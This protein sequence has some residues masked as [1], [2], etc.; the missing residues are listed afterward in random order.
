MSLIISLFGILLTIFLVVGVHEFG[1]F[2]VA[3]LSGIKVLRFS[4]GFG[5]P[6]YRWYD[7]KGTE[8]VLAAIP[9]GGYVKMV[10]EREENVLASD[11][12][13]SFNRQPLYKRIAVICAGPFSNLIFAALLYWLLFVIGFTTIKPIIGEV[14][15]NSIAAMAGLKPQQEILQIDHE[16][17]SGW[18]AVIIRLFEHAGDQGTLQIQATSPNA[19]QSTNYQLN[20][21]SWKMDELK[22]DPLKS[23][24][25][26]PYAP[27]IPAV[28]DVIQPN[29]PAE[30]AGLKPKDQIIAIGNQSIKDWMEIVNIIA[31]APEQ[32]LEFHIIRDKKEMTLPV[33][34]GVK[35]AFFVKKYGYLGMMPHY[36]L[37]P[38]L[39]RH[40]QYGPIAAIPK[41]YSQVKL[42]THM[43]FI[44]LEKL[45]EG[46][47]SLKSLGGPLTIFESAGTAL[48]NGIIPFM[49]FLAFL[50]ISIGIINIFPIPGLDGGHLLFQIIELI[51]RRPLSE[52]TQILLYRLGLILLM[53]L[54]AQAITNDILRL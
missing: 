3:R 48:N 49:S 17:T 21:A 44:M 42:F 20:L 7:K 12:P 39:L 32:T 22:P 36:V 10:D 11:L 54:I 4:I 23:L 16:P 33:T 26:E 46:K 18:Y 35:H 52:R 15:P 47:V 9:L 14:T 43:N 29:S 6:L 25:I 50:S 41:A 28:I 34:I 13:Y 24:G 8:Y 1:H 5:K 53:L 31:F 30:Q 40:E 2:I 19:T 51:I 27:K 37:P 45:I 38:N